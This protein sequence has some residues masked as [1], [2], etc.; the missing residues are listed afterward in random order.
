[1]KV[2]ASVK[3]RCK[4]CY[5][6]RRKGRIYVYCKSNPKH[7]QRQGFHTIACGCNSPQTCGVGDITSYMRRFGTSSSSHQPFN[8]LSLSPIAPTA[9]PTASS[10]GAMLSP[11]PL[12]APNANTLNITSRNAFTSLFVPSVSVPF[13]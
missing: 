13:V 4:D 11:A 12:L 3:A 8:T 2:R 5:V 6:V 7:K 9:S 1:M 10:L